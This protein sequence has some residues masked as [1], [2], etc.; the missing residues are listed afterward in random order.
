MKIYSNGKIVQPNN[1]T[2]GPPKESYR[3]G[4]APRHTQF[5][6]LL[7]ATQNGRP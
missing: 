5:S 7:D 1:W 2:D 4:H 3:P 6:I